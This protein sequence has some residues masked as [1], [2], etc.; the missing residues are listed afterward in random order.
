MIRHI[1]ELGFERGVR[2]IGGMVILFQ[3]KEA[4]YIKLPSSSVVIIHRWGDRSKGRYKEAWKPFTNYLKFTKR[5]DSIYDIIGMAN[6]YELGFI[7]STRPMPEIPKN[8]KK[9]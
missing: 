2:E 6:K 4:V 3:S 7:S 5:I 1:G 8:I 9:Y